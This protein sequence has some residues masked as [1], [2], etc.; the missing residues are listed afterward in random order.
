VDIMVDRFDPPPALG[1]ARHD[2]YRI[3][4]RETLF[5]VPNGD[6]Q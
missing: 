3:R 5:S 4:M 1:Y 6:E 2:S